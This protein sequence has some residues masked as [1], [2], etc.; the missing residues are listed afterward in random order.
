MERTMGFLDVLACFGLGIGC[1]M[2]AICITATIR[3][4]GSFKQRLDH[5]A[6]I[7]REFPYSHWLVL[8]LVSGCWLISKY[9]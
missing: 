8:A 4:N 7:N 5:V 9:I 1:F 3:Y 6:G 2:V